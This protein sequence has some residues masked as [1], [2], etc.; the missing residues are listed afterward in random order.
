VR[1]GEGGGAGSVLYC[2]VFEGVLEAGARNGDGCEPQGGARICVGG[3]ETFESV[4]TWVS[5]CFGFVFL[6][7]TETEEGVGLSGVGVWFW[8]SPPGMISSIH[9][10][11]TVQYSSTFL[12]GYLALTVLPAPSIKYRTVQ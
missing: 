7:A 12:P 9:S 11:S 4:F 1:A 6:L 8:E 3:S 5:R 2:T 10:Y